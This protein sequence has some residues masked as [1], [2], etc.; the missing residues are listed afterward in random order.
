MVA[1][2]LIGTQIGF[3]GALLIGGGVVVAIV[4]GGLILIELLADAADT[5]WNKNKA[6]WF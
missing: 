6:E 3:L 4:V 1:G 2:A 5:E